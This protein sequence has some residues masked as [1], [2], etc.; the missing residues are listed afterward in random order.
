MVGA[1]LSASSSLYVLVFFYCRVI[2]VIVWEMC[3]GGP[4]GSRGEIH[5]AI[6]HAQAYRIVSVLMDG[7]DIGSGRQ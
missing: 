5:A 2:T 1:G 4:V 3:R 7:L 6:I